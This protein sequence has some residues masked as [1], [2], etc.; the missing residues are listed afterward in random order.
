MPLPLII[1]IAA[2]VA[3]AVGVGTGIKGGV[4]LVDAKNT[5]K[6]A[7][8]R[9][10]ANQKRHKNIDEDT[11]KNMDKLAILEMNVLS[12]FKEFADVVEKIKNRPSFAEI[13][14]GDVDIPQFDPKE[15]EQ[16]SIGASVLLGGLG[17]A[18]LGTAGAFAA[19]GATTSA[20]MA[21]GTASTGTAISSLSGAAATNATL[22]A[23]G[24]GSLASGGGGVAL[25]TA[26][27]S[28]AAA[29][30]AILVGGV[31]FCAVG[32]NTAKKADK[33]YDQMLENE[34]V[35]N[36]ICVYLQELNGA[37]K[38]YYNDLFMAKM[39]YDKHL[40]RMKF[41][42]DSNTETDGTVDWGKLDEADR[43]TIKNVVML[44]GLLYHMCKVKL[45][46]KAA[47]ENQVNSVNTTEIYD[48]RREC[49][50][51][52]KAVDPTRKYSAYEIESHVKNI[53][54]KACNRSSTHVLSNQVISC[55]GGNIASI[56]P[57][58][59]IEFGFKFH[60]SEISQILTVGDAIRIVNL[61]V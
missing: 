57:Q 13:K 14:I 5:L 34:K 52:L 15:L 28:G 4:D 51:I 23:I 42:V 40:S 50:T 7:K 33:A 27:L 41:V 38:S 29:G 36:S 2:G 53:I 55:I 35:I 22:A 25:G 45:V 12:S 58:L 8:E 37:A 17:G 24:G 31:I 30:V 43:T 39:L 1:G 59:E 49:T 20:V 56:Y 9:D 19:S 18:T 10:E 3:A 47:K 46:K 48:A 61:H 6:K 26:V 21:L 60:S 11:C 54:A 44:V 32:A 16:A